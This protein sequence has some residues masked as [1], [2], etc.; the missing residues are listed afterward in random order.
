MSSIKPCP[1]LHPD[2]SADLWSCETDRLTNH[3][4]PYNFA[5]TI[6]S[7]EINVFELITKKN[8]IDYQQDLIK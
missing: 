8:I 5:Y 3:T 4:L 6:S 2:P 1:G 7:L